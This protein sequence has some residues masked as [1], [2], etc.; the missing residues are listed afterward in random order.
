MFKSMSD[1]STRLARMGFPKVGFHEISWKW[2]LAMV[3]VLTAEAFTRS[4]LQLLGETADSVSK[5][6]ECS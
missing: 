2:S 3:S 5:D 1:W 4:H 6:S